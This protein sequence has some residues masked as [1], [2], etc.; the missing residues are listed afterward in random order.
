MPDLSSQRFVYKQTGPAPATSLRHIGRR[1]IEIKLRLCCWPAEYSARN[2]FFLVHLRS[3]GFRT[4]PNTL[5]TD[6][7][8]TRQRR[9]FKGL[10]LADWEIAWIVISHSAP[11]R[12]T[13]KA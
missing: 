4:Y 7:N 3:A 10:S 1:R 13:A 12:I 11:I 5:R 2:A 6:H 9:I 8:P